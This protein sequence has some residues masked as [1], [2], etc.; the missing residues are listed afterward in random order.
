MTDFTELADVEIDGRSFMLRPIHPNFH[1]ALLEKPNVVAYAIA[2]SL[3]KPLE[4][5]LGFFWGDIELSIELFNVISGISGM[6]E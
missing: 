5:A 4:W 2:M 6:D 1:K 3:G